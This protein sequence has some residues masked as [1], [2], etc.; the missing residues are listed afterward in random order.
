MGTSPVGI[1]RN[2][3]VIIAS[4]QR[5]FDIIKG[6]VIASCVHWGGGGG[7]GG[8]GTKKSNLW[9]DYPGCIQF[10]YYQPENR[11]L[12]KQTCHQFSPKYSQ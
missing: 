8:G 6:V 5:L 1:W 4:K 3:N 9:N 2:D 11:A 10:K 7:G 12:Q